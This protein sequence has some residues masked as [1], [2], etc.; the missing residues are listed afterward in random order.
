MKDFFISYNSAD[1][2]WAEWIAWELEEAKYTTVLQAWDFRPG[3][4][5]VLEMHK[6]A[7][8]AERTIALLSPTYLKSIFTQP[9]WAAAFVD[10]PTGS[11]RK[12][13][14]IRVRECDLTGLLKAIVYID[15]VGKSQEAAKE[16]LLTGI[17]KER[18]KPDI[19]PGFPGASE[20]TVKEQ[21]NFPGQL[22]PVWNIPHQ[23]NRNFTGRESLLDNLHKALTS[24]QTTALTQ[25]IKG[26]GGVGKTQLALEYAYRYAAE[27]KAV[28]WLRSE[29]S[30]TLSGDLA[31]MA[32]A[33]C[34]PEAEAQDQKATVQAVRNWLGKNKDWL[35]VYD[36]A[37]DPETIR[38]YLPPG[39]TGHVII[40]SRHHAWR[41]VAEPLEV[42][43]LERSEAVD[44]LIKRSGLDDK[45][46][47]DKLANELGDLPLA[48]EQAAAYIEETDINYADY[49]E[50]F[51]T[52]RKEL[53]GGAKPPID[54]PE[55]VATTW[56]L[57]MEQARTEAPGAHD[58]LM[59]CAYLAPDNIPK[60]LLISGKKY[61]PES[62]ANTVADPLRL[63]RAIVALRHYSMI[64]LDGD[65]ISVHRLVQ[66]VARDLA[67]SESG[68]K[69]AES[70]A[71]LINLEFPFK[72]HDLSTWSQ[73]KLLMP[74]VLT[75]TEHA[76]R[77]EILPNET[78]WL[79]NEAGL[80]LKGRADFA[81]A[82]NLLERAL[83]IFEKVYGH[84][85]PKVATLVNNLGD[86][87]QDMGD[88][89]GAKSHYERALEID[90]KAFGSDHPEVAID[91]NNL[92]FVLKAMGDLKAAQAHYERA[93]KI[94]ERA[95]GH[96]HPNVAT[97]VNNLGD[98]L[99]DLG[100][101]KGAQPHFRR[102]LDIFR[103][104]LG[105]EHPSTK[106]VRE[107]LEIVEKQLKSK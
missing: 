95:Y 44:F 84:N 3:S 67:E 74:H 104:F 12:L 46:G 93:L 56:N 8:E 101:L 94:D 32:A 54:Y 33:L 96:D 47:A 52:R 42:Q 88:F 25:A 81:E 100:D 50:L 7:T 102:A 14:P 26:L 13:I 82:R 58:L 61:Y 40:T 89:K 34:L 62:L 37:P 6:A 57:A 83:K 55:T 15:F 66:A 21:P 43:V 28:W 9:E 27:Y 35:L 103:K 36:N 99:R 71:K 22:P 60:E 69:W 19:K 49:L 79:L 73:S 38:V 90:E 97:D 64:Q 91:V 77:L 70:A 1:R 16:A 107:N 39:S 85:H 23:R 72:E 105:D 31:S 68:N 48:L 11:K 65:S 59:L 24:G 4:N 92:G 20:R 41:G 18:A 86:V 30:A 5:F 17:K 63:D 98:V 87:L 2:Q 10:D 29:D 106:I 51:K 76:E 45:P 53:W 75:V 80:Y 78:T